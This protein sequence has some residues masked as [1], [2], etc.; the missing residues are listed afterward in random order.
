MNEMTLETP[1]HLRCIG[2]GIYQSKLEIV[3]VSKSDI[4]FIKNAAQN[5]QRKRARICAHLSNEQPLHEMMIALC[6]DSYIHPHRH[7]GKSE[8]FH[9]VEGIVDVV[10]MND[11]GSIKEVVELGDQSTERNF[12]YRLSNSYFHTLIIHSAI[13]V[14]HEVTNGPFLQE[15]TEMAP[16]APNESETSDAARYIEQLKKKLY[17]DS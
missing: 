7:I 12:Y 4:D 9:I 2:D 10:V 3:K 8:S 6:S 15:Q 17:G 13:L 14:V 1:S 11:D 5:V 16:F